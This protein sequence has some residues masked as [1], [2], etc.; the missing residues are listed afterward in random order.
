MGAFMK[1]K[2]LEYELTDGGAVLPTEAAYDR[3]RILVCLKHKP[4]GWVNIKTTA[5]FITAAQLTE[6]IQKQLKWELLFRLQESS[7][8][9]KEAPAFLSEGI[10]IIVCTRDRTT[11]LAVCLEALQALDYPT[12]EIIVVDNAPSD[13][14]THQLVA[15]M[16]VKY[17]REEKPGLDWARNRGISEATYE[18]V[19]FT[20]DDAV[21]DRYWLQAIANVMQNE[22][23]AAA[24][25]LVAPAELD[26]EAQH[27]FEL[28]Y[29]GMGH[30]FERQIFSG[31]RLSDRQILR[32][33]STGIGVNMAFRSSVLSRIGG[34]N[35]AL[36]VGTPSHGGGDVEMFQRLLAKGYTFVYDPSMLVWHTHR[37]ELSKTMLQIRDNG[38]SFGCYLICCFRNQTVKR[39]AVLKFFLKDWLL[40]W[41]L[42]NLVKPPPL[43]PRKFALIEI[44]GMLQS[45]FA[46]LATQK[47]AKKI[48]A[49]SGT[50]VTEKVKAT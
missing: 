22:A 25:G 16:P 12:Y 32:A 38:R 10:S 14:S 6:S 23:I 35:P 15:H 50:Y 5:P 30:G 44:V 37:R 46:Y 24:T 7:I 31:C 47:W 49:R 2:V 42:K 43:L 40:N 11:S 17:V 45:P 18:L 4:I 13:N 41:G 39:T 28:G 36:D 3:Y 33:G 19:A 20:D 34:F 27:I 1:T 9:R 26:T 21:V 8:A 48:A 29:G